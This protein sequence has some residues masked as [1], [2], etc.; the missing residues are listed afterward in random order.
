MII[1]PKNI[2]LK[3][4]I[5]LIQSSLDQIKPVVLISSEE[6]FNEIAN[7]IDEQ[8]EELVTEENIDEMD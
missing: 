5:H 4:L 6:N 3:N 1:L 7:E 2:H 8:N